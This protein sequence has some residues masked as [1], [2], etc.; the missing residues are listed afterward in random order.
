MM[1]EQFAFDQFLGDG[2]AVHF[3]ERLAGARAHGVQGVRHQFF[4]GAAFAV[5]Q[6]APVGAGHQRQLLAQGLH[7][8]ALADDAVARFGALPEAAVLEL[9]PAVLAARS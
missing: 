4:A 1:A 2:R 3:D 6:H 5:D 9:Q 8:H 7:G